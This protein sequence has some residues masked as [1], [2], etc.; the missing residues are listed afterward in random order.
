MFGSIN[1]MIK[2][3]EKEFVNLLSSRLVF[4]IMALY[5]IEFISF[6]INT[7]YPFDGMPSRISNVKDP[8]HAI[9]VLLAYSL[10][11]Y[12]SLIAVVLGFTSMS[13]EFDGKAL[14]TMLVKP[15]Y[16][17]TIING[18]ILG[19]LGF[20]LCL[21]LFTTALYVMFM[22]VYFGIV[23]NSFQKLI[24]LYIPSFISSLPLV[25][26]LSLLCFFFFYALSILY[27]LLFKNQSF[28]LF[29]G[30]LSWIFLFLVLGSINVT[31]YLG[32]FF[33]DM[34]LGNMIGG[35]ST[36]TI[37]YFILGNFDLGSALINN[38]F[39][40]LKLSLYCF[41]ALIGAYIAFIRRD[42]A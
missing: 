8:A 19:A 36:Y 26:V 15:L 13:E 11:W 34:A 2:V 31:G 12:G 4:I 16:R 1:N 35:F 42:V 37:L 38:G 5:I 40:F 24:E 27:A 25:L 9:S 18:K 7:T 10:C 20:V 23:I 33:H 41:I 21:F 29:M 39:E 30:I 6:I 32:F 22:L 3:A 14:N 17:D 28:S